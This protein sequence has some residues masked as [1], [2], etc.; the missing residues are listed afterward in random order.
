M[1]N[2]SR[3]GATAVVAL[4]F[5]AG[6]ATTSAQKPTHRWVSN[7]NAGRTEYVADH[8]ACARDQF[9]K[10]RE[11]AMDT[12]SPEYAKYVA[13]MNEQGYKLVAYDQTERPQAR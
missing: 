9:G 7:D 5:V 6:C 10:D 11:R 3:K 1:A 12:S 13:C 8:R 2:F 4:A